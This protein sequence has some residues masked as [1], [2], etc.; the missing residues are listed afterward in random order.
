MKSISFLT[1]GCYSN[2]PNLSHTER[3][4]IMLDAALDFK[5][6]TRKPPKDTTITMRAR[7]DIPHVRSTIGGPT[8]D[9]RIKSLSRTI[10]D[11]DPGGTFDVR[12]PV[13]NYAALFSSTPSCP[14]E[15]ILVIFQVS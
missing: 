13:K 9:D 1:V 11:P 10:S 6:E 7:T 12:G 2:R 5:R 15:K 4:D 14:S 8:V 3:Y